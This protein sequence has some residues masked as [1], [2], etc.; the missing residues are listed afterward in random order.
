MFKCGTQLRATALLPKAPSELADSINCSMYRNT[1]SS[2]GRCDE[3]NLTAT[4]P[5]TAPKLVT[6]LASSL[7]PASRL[8]HSEQ[9]E[10]SLQQSKTTISHRSLLHP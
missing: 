8:A 4:K 6:I 10:E 2:I 9:I 7:P 5:G 1:C 3:G